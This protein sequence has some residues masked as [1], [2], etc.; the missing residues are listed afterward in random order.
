MVTVH[1]TP[2]Y[3][4]EKHFNIILPPTSMWED[5][6]SIYLSIPVALTWNLG[7]LWNTSFHFNFLILDSQQESL[8]GESAL[9][10]AAT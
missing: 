4:S 7:H 10:K 2:S 8:D 6:L 5:Y 1:I 9:R 3:F